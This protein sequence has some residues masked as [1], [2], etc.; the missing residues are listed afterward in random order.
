MSSSSSWL[1]PIS[2]NRHLFPLDEDTLSALDG[3]F[4]ER[5][6]MAGFM[7][8]AT[9]AK[10][11]PLEAAIEAAI[12][13]LGRPCVPMLLGD[14]PQ[15]LFEELPS[16]DAMVEQDAAMLQEDE[17]GIPD[18]PPAEPLELEQNRLRRSRGRVAQQLV[19][20]KS[21]SECLDMLTRSPSIHAALTQRAESSETGPVELELRVV[22]EGLPELELVAIVTPTAAEGAASRLTALAQRHG[23]VFSYCLSQQ[24]GAILEAVRL[25]VGKL[26]VCPSPV[27]LR[28]GVEPK[29]D[30]TF[31]D[32]KSVV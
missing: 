28:F 27:A 26:E 6:E 19:M 13:E 5:E 22:D 14:T 32:R 25:A 4:D 8:P 21:G 15:D 11:A 7:Q 12:Q 31:L 30:G 3:A 18:M 1:D 17:A 24:H 29:E 2:L 9:K 10:L 20:V 23:D 16:F